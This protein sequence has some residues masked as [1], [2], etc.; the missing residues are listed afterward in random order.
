LPEQIPAKV[1]EQ[2][3]QAPALDTEDARQL[4][5]IER[6]AILQG[7]K[8]HDFN[9]TETAKALGISRRALIYKLQRFRKLGFEIDA[10]A[11]E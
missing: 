4:E 2:A 3:S 6:Q 5:E 7:L 10:P 1:R 9:R 11:G 8:Q